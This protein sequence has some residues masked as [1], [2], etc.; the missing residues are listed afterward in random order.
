MKVL[1]F[2]TSVQHLFWRAALT[3]RNMFKDCGRVLRNSPGKQYA[4]IYDYITLPIPLDCVSQYDAETIEGVRSLAKR[5]I[6]RMVDFSSIA[7]NPYE[8]DQ[9]IS[10]IRQAYDII[11]EMEDEYDE[12]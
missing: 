8:S 1:T 12:V 7:E 9:L 3:Q 5:E 2:L 10:E 4:H 11:P 6:S